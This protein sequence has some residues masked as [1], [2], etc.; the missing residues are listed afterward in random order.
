[1]RSIVKRSITAL[2]LLLTSPLILMVRL[3]RVFRSEKLFLTYGS[4]LSLIPGTVGSYIRVA[5]YLGTL[6]KMSPDV[7]IGF[8]SFFSRSNASVGDNVS[9]GAYCILGSV[10]IENNVLIASRVSI[11]SGRHQHGD[12][13]S[14]DRS[15]K[16]AFG[17]IRIGQNTWVG[18]AAVVL[19][20]VGKNCIVASGAVVVKEMPD[21]V[22][23][24]G[25]PASVKKQ[26]AASG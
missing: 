24:A 17:Q 23:V 8:G 18:E 2:C 3:A 26:M 15:G 9:I 16:N 7:A 20:T 19:N 14:Q 21:N 4:F 6:S 10:D 12:F 13:E 11:P 1:M 22:L 25:N 5:Y